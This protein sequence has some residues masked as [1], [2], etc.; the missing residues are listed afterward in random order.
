V[1]IDLLYLNG[2]VMNKQDGVL[3]DLLYVDCSEVGDQQ[4]SV[5]T[6]LPRCLFI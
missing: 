1:I 4:E 3:I 6:G 5:V 2:G